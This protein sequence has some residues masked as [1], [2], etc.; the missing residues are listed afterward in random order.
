M[1]IYANLFTHTETGKQDIDTIPTEVFQLAQELTEKL[2]G[3]VR[4]LYYG[5]MGEYDGVAIVEFP[6]AKSMEQWR[7]AFE[8][9]GTHHIEHYEV[10]EAEEYF[11]MIEEATD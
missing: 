9:E 7:L 2:G 1:P 5:S 3:E 6:D 10:F 11:E 4:D 8:R